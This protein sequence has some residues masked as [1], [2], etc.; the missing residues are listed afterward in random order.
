MAHS[1]EI[2]GAEKALLGL[3]ENIN[4]NEYKVDLFLLRHQGALMKY[5]PESIHLMPEN[6][7]YASLGIPIKDVIK[8]K[9]FQMVVY[10]FL[11]KQKAKRRIK[12]LNFSRDNNVANEYSHKYTINI[13]PDISDV[14]YDLAISFMSPHYFVSKKIKAKKKIAWIHTDY[15][16][17][18]VDIN[19]E[20]AM[21]DQYDD[22]IS[23]SNDVTRSFMKTF[24]TLQSK[25]FEIENIM[26]INYMKR[27]ANEFTVEN[28]I[29]SDGSIKLLSIGRFVYPK[30]FDDIP[31]ICKAIRDQGVDVKWYLIGFGSDE[32]L[33]RKKIKE[34]D[35]QS[36][37]IILGQKENPYPYIQAC[38]IYVQPSRY[39]GKSIA[40]REAQIFLKPVIIT[41]YSTA[42][43]QLENGVDG[44]IVS[45]DID[46][47]AAKIMYLIRN[48]ELQNQLIHNMQNRDYVNKS[49][50]EKLYQLMR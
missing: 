38:D 35:M 37:V 13:L 41:E 11:G 8:K 44:I 27:L 34:A 28:E 21:W 45:M 22:I 33:I 9:D 32:T 47:I 29:K 49:E 46:V 40:V 6:D 42:H 5:I 48:Q 23:I 4:T 10:R 26:P 43:S 2:G 31:A 24:P 25:I 20:I 19:S 18:E 1:M 14:E 7:R 15:S 30:R 39:E 3:L 12:K 17:F 16:T 50:I 36:Y